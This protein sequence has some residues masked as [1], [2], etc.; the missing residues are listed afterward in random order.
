MRSGEYL[1]SLSARCAA[2]RS[3]QHATRDTLRDR[4]RS[5][6]IHPPERPGHA[7]D[8]SRPTQPTLPHKA[9]R[10]AQARSSQLHLHIARRRSRMPARSWV[11]M[12]GRGR[13]WVITGGH[14]WAVGG[15][16]WSWVG[17]GGHGWSWVVM[18]GYGWA[19]MGVGGRGWAWVVMGGHGW[20]WVVMGGR[21]WAWVGVGG[22][23]W[24][25][26][27]MGGHG[28]RGTGDTRDACGTSA[29]LEA[30]NVM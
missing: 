22:H 4:R 30:C 12:G 18:G 14:G 16:G 2:T 17:V 15:R 6:F 27:G 9:A 23:G 11:I 3:R 26:V 10:G 25:W 13:A 20:A 29:L 21:G 1:G 28:W 8:D 24:S 19:W 5:S 7:T